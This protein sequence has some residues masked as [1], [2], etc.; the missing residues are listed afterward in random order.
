MVSRP[1]TNSNLSA[2]PPA[3]L[4]T[5][6]TQQVSS[7]VASQAIDTSYRKSR[8]LWSLLAVG[9]VT[10]LL[11]PFRQN[12]NSTTVALALLLATLFIATLFGSRP[13]LL[14]SLVAMLVFN[15]FF[16]PPL[17]TFAIADPQNWIALSAFFLTA[18][19]VGELSARARKRAEEAVRGRREIEG[20]Y[21]QLREAFEQ[22]SHAEALRQSEALKSALLEA[23]THDIRT[24]LTSIKASVTTLLDDGPI[25]DD[26]GNQQLGLDL[27]GRTELLEV[28][29]EEADRLNSFIQSLI[30]LA[31]I[32]A[33]ALVLRRRSGV[34][35]EEII[36]AVLKRAEPLTRAHPLAVEIEQ[37]LAVARV[38]PEAIA[39]VLYTLVD[40][41]TK[42]A[43][44]HTP[45]RIA[46]RRMTN[47]LIEIAVEDQGP[48][49]APPLRE[50]VFDKFFS[51]TQTPRQGQAR[52]LGIGLGLAIAR[53]IV[54]AHGGRIWVEDGAHGTGARLAF[55]VPVGD[56]EAGGHENPK[57]ARRMAYSDSNE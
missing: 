2:N 18:I 8:Y 25:V 11:A 45:I 52:P 38:D 24:P 51:A 43:P 14:A 19:T 13:A 53:G 6:E 21:E 46:A 50:H 57:A 42:Y 44:L 10:I 32:E 28:I 54:S 9:M 15:F 56:K 35:I 26:H 39:E 4:R 49:I 41:A 12:I 3:V 30:E 33:G 31:R 34:V 22:A 27:E 20:L 17:H 55:T 36:A 16:L 1:S 5:H 47:N 7:T 29:N 40:N 37:D 23:V 48:G